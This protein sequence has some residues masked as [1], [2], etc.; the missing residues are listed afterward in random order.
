[1]NSTAVAI[2]DNT[3]NVIAAATSESESSARVRSESVTPRSPASTI[4]RSTSA[5]WKNAA[6]HSPA[7]TADSGSRMYNVTAS[8]RSERNGC[9]IQPPKGGAGYA[10]GMP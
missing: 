8:P 2:I 1:M 4:C 7:N 5:R 10:P 6:A 9:G 3:R